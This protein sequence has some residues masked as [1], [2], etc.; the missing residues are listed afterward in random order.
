MSDD[1]EKI[2]VIED[3]STLRRDIIE[4]L[5]YEGYYVTGAENGKVGVELAFSYQPDLII[6]DIMM[7]EMD[8][9]QVMERLKADQRTAAIPFIFLT[10]RT[11]RADIRYGMGAGADDYLTKPFVA[12]ELI[13]S[14][15]A[16]LSK[17][18]RLDTITQNR[19]RELSE[20]I[21]TALPHELR[22][23]LNTV[24][25]FSDML[26]DEAETIDPV[27]L[28]EWAG[29]INDAGHRLYRLVENYLAYVRA[30]ALLQD[31]SAVREVYEHTLDYP[32]SVIHL[33][34]VSRAKMYQREV[35]LKINLARDNIK[36][37]ISEGD[38]GK[39][40]T[41]LVD[42][43][44]KFSETGSVVNLETYVE[45]QTYTLQVIDH[46]R[47]L[48]KEQIEAVG[49]YM[50]FDRWLYEQQGAGLGLV[51]VTRFLELYGGS[52]DI[53]SDE[54]GTRVLVKLDCVGEVM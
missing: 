54:T 8:G 16:Q 22:T 9:F 37:R 31:N 25:G 19:L 32:G 44:L 24:I 50:Q 38:L 39:I 1:I 28:R 17:R 45:A 5:T 15:N 52:L 33:Y 27:R 12:T 40:V 41:E 14:V 20:S 2:L 51:I 43:A 30:T 29:F 4:I 23:P 35:D 49:T 3:A 7:P 6:C 21:L 13:D 18:R 47:G 11:D 26:L 10:A 46:G 34:A 36:I 48:S 42:N 53:D